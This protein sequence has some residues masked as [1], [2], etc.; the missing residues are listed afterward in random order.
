MKM[1]FPLS[2]FWESSAFRRMLGSY[3]FGSFGLGISSTMYSSTEAA[4]LAVTEKVIAP[5][6]PLLE[7]LFPEWFAD[8]TMV[9]ANGKLFIGGIAATEVISIVLG[10]LSIFLIL[11]RAVGDLNLWLHK[12]R[13]NKSLEVMAEQKK[14][15]K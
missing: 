11:V 2:I 1:S 12:R 8:G 5:K 13:L 4:E 14:K 6:A 10:L 9:M 7:T 15:I 3:G